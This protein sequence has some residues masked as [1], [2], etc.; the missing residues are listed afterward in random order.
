MDTIKSASHIA[1]PPLPRPLVRHIPKPPWWDQSCQQQANRYNKAYYQYRKH[2]TLANYLEL[3]QI[4]TQNRRWYRDKKHQFWSDYLSSLTYPTTMTPIWKFAK[5]IIN[6]CVS[7]STSTDT[8]LTHYPNAS[9]NLLS[10]F[11]LPLQS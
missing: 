9:N 4:Q 7:C 10:L 6:P 5:C 11:Y 8:D 3:K 1:S 2:L